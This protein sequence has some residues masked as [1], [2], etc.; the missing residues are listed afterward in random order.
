MVEIPYVRDIQFEYGVTQQVAPGI[1]RV[2]AAN[3]G[4]FTYTGS[5]TYIIGDGEVAVIDP[6]PN[7]P[8]HVDAIL[9]GLKPGERITHI[10][11]THTH[12]D[13]SPAAAPLKA[14]TGA[15]T[16]AYGPHGGARGR[17][18]SEEGG[19]WDFM[20]DV[21]VAHGDV[22]EG[23]GWSAEAV[24]TPGHTSNH[25]SWQYREHKALFTGDHVMGW[26]TSVIAP[27]D[28]DMKSYMDSLRLL[29]DRDDEIYWPTHGPAITDPKPFVQ[30]FITHREEREAQIM[31]C[32][33]SDARY[34]PAMVKIMY[35]NVPE[36]LHPA[37]SR[38]V[39]AHLEHMIDTGR[40]VSSTET[41]TMK[42]LYTAVDN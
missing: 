35:A 21:R 12:M 9:A 25:M 24:F 30:A 16:Y 8:E 22:V 13:H 1:R 37:A 11:I 7:L 2:I 33:R 29:L 20:P 41:A 31:A 23:N 28:G 34:I 15:K 3:K 5:G 32:L 27:P 26:S 39:L 6:G 19:D 38:S 42:S 14:L 17:G 40:V 18:E 10:L 36:N 4:P